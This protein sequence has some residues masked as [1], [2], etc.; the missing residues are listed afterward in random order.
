MVVWTN[1]LATPKLE[2]VESESNFTGAKHPKIV[3]LFEI[4]FLS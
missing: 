2:P 4:N 3:R 1:Q